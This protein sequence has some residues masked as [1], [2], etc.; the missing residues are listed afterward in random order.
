MFRKLLGA[1]QLTLCFFLE[2]KRAIYGE[3]DYK[4]YSY[5]PQEEYFRDC[6]SLPERSSVA[7]N[8]TESTFFKIKVDR[9][10]ALRLSEP[11]DD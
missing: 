1:R 6:N 9:H 11:A 5:P 7:S 4:K 10:L 3:L 2:R 8:A